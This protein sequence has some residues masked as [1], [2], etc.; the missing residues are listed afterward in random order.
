MT[1]TERIGL[2]VAALGILG[3]GLGF[4]LR[5]RWATL[6]WPFTDSAYGA[7]ALSYL[8][9]ASILGSIG[10]SILWVAATNEGRAIAGG[11]A[12]LTLTG[13]G[14]AAT[15]LWAYAQ[16]G[17]RGALLFAGVT[18]LLALASVALF[19]RWRRVPFRDLR[20]VP[21][22]VRAA[23]AVYAVLLVIVGL[24]LVTGRPNVFPWR[25][26]QEASVIYGVIF[27]G[28]AVYFVYGLLHPVWG[29]AGG[30]MVGFL[31]YDL[32][33]VVPFLQRLGTV[34][35]ELRASLWLY[36]A[37]VVASG[38]IAA[39]SLFFDPRTRFARG[40]RARAA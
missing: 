10:A 28:A 14:C 27:L 32:V 37:V 24:L 4:A 33:L 38:L 25:I 16:G 9:I 22:Y 31:A 11:A 34:P 15:G 7:G 20:P 40:P 2:V 5:Q 18:A 13:L 23:F 1:R 8:F 26:G 21:A 35:P 3:L 6:L 12:E 19:L 36:T 39:W 29:N 30:Q 17:G